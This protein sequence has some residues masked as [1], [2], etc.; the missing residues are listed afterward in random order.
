[1]IPPGVLA[2]Y[3]YKLYTGVVGKP[4]ENLAAPCKFEKKDKNATVRSV[5]LG[6][7]KLD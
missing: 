1:M 4:E 2:K 6:L 3:V 5:V 7:G